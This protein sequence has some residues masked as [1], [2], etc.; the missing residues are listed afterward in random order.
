MS[1]MAANLALSMESIIQAAADNK[2]DLAAEM[3]GPAI[4]DASFGENERLEINQ[5]YF[6]GRFFMERLIVYD[7][8]TMQFFL[9]DLNT[10]L[11]KWLSDSSLSLRLGQFFQQLLLGDLLLARL[12]R[13]SLPR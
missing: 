10:G 8:A 9:Y 2:P 11:W 6:A 13:G 12:C 5:L 3:F 7:L 1:D 4:V